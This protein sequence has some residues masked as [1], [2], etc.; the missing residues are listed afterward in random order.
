MVTVGG[1]VTACEGDGR[2]HKTIN[3]NIEAVLV[4]SKTADLEGNAE[5][6]SM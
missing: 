1:S 2:K 5:K 3:K 6:L 4:V